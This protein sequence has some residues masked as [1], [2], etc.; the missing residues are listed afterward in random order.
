LGRLSRG[1]FD[2]FTV[3]FLTQYSE[4]PLHLFG[5]LGIIAFTAGFI[6]NAY[7]T[8]L[9]FT[10]HRPIGN[11]PLL[12][13]GVLLIIIGV[14]FFSLGLLADMVTRASFKGANYTIRRELG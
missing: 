7:L 8:A 5:W 12:M 13:L 9:W 6:I 10:G 14:Q 3:L 11:R 4:R 2:L 1:F